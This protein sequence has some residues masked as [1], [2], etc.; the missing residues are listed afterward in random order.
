MTEPG[1]H[2]APGVMDFAARNPSYAASRLYSPKYFSAIWMPSSYI[3]WN[4][5]LY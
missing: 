4:L 5:S 2:A 3:F 1:T